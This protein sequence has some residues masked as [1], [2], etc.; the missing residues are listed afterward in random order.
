MRLKK[1]GRPAALPQ[2][3][4]NPGVMGGMWVLQGTRVPADTVLAEV[5]AGTSEA[6][7]H[8]SYPSLPPRS[9]EACL[10]WESLGR[11]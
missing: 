3:V 1:P 7:I 2:I 4:S 9:V 11:P 8:R 6:E 10:L 5:Q